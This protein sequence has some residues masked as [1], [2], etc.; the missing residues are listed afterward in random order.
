MLNVVKILTLWKIRHVLQSVDVLQLF[1]NENHTHCESSINEK[2][3]FAYLVPIVLIYF[4]YEDIAGD[5]KI[6]S[7]YKCG[8]QVCGLL[9]A[10]GD[11]QI[12]PS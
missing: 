6:T 9:L 5:Q 12:E 3:I 1:L 4:D 2:R 10:F 8:F 11:H 7:H